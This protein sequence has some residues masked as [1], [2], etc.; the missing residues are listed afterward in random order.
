VGVT[1]LILRHGS[2]KG[3]VGRALFESH[4]GLTFKQIIEEQWWLSG[5]S[6]CLPRM[7]PQASIF[8]LRVI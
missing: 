5:E 1:D 2:K 6:T 8:R 4:P 7:W 3:R